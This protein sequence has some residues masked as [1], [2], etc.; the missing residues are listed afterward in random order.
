MAEKPK[1]LIIR[2]LVMYIL[3]LLFMVLLIFLPAGSL[4]FR[5]G[6]LFI[7]VLFTAMFIVLT[8]LMVKD[9]DLLA[10]RL[11]TKEKEKPQ[12]AYLTLSM[13][14]LLFTFIIPGLDYRFHWS[15]VP[16]PIV[17]VATVIMLAGYLIFFAVMRQ[18]TYASR[19]IE[20]Q[21]GQK[22]IDTGLYSLVR[23]PMYL[24]A[25]ILFVPAPLVLGSWYA[26]IPVVLVPI[27]LIIRIMNE[28][29]VLV[30]GLKGYSEYMKKVR[31]RLIPYIWFVTIP[32]I[33][34]LPSCKNKQMEMS[35]KALREKADK[36]CQDNLLLDSHIDWPMWIME[37]PEDIS[38]QTLTGD[39]DLVRAQKGGLNAVLSVIYIN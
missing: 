12:K 19:V 37:F 31:Y 36:I 22:L 23:H 13:I 25:S 27:L 35:D 32:L 7:G 5:N 4:K 3:S 28:E 34:L 20:I 38:G 16:V 10:K 21:E 30:D 39:F 1:L 26:L 29:K 14:V 2:A 18:N 17:V 8:W 15:D 33:V 6:W 24:G 11:K 9:P